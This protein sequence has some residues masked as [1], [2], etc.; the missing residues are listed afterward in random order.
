MHQFA[1]GFRNRTL[2]HL[3]ISFTTDIWTSDMWPISLLS[4]H[5]E[6]TQYQSTFALQS[7]VLQANKFGEEL[8]LL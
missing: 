1:A 6:R 2:L 4:L 5:T 7:A 8:H 3:P